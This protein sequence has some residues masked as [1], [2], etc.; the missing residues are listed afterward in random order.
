VS[1]AV[2]FALI[3][4]ILRIVGAQAIAKMSG[5]D[6]VATVTLGSIVA[7]V[8]LTRDVTISDAAAALVTMIALQEIMRRAQS[9]WMFA[10]HAVREPPL[11]VLWDGQLLEDRLL[12]RGIS[13][14]E[15]RAACRK[16][17]MRSLEDAQLVVLENDGE[18]SVVERSARES[19]DSALLGLPIP[20]RPENSP[21][22]DGHEARPAPSDRLP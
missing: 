5:Y 8:A 20:G 4:A 19:D 13:A 16:H 14:D 7:T 17:G 15:V 2:V 10:H 3:T 21:R 22:G 6:M 1:T 9:R 12:R 18:W 11:V